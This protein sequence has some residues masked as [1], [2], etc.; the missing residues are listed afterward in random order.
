[1]ETQT[2][3]YESRVVRGRVE[4]WVPHNNEEIAF[5]YPSVGPDTYKNVR[6]TI[7]ENGQ[8]VPTGDYTAS[9]LHSTYCDD[10]VANEPEFENVREIMK[11]RWLW[12][13]NKNLWTENG[14]Y[15]IQDLDT[16]W[17]SQPLVMNE[18]EKML[19]GGK[20]I[21]EVRFSEDGRV[22]FAPNGSYNLGVNTPENFA[23]DG[24]IIA[25]CGVEG[26]EKLGEVSA[27]FRYHPRVYGVEIEKGQTPEQRLSVVDGDYGDRLIFLGDSF[28]DSGYCPSFGV[29]K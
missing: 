7:L 28:G 24:F 10:S 6:K 8:K 9:L 27:K 2:K 29:L 25:S 4:L 12:V 13:F 11:N 17:E 16:I 5:I 19:K 18:L 22:R 14:V 21:N 26:A 1:M 15:V 3:S 23:K 20:E